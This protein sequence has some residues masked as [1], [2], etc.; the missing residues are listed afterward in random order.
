MADGV[1]AHERSPI[2]YD[3]LR[4]IVVGA[5]MYF[6]ETAWHNRDSSTTRIE[7]GFVCNRID[8]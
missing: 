2:L 3:A 7:R 5:R 8:T 6:I 1:F 4:Q